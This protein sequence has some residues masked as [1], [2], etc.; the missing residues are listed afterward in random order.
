MTSLAEAPIVRRA[1]GAIHRRMVSVRAF[2]PPVRFATLVA[3]G[4]ALLSFLVPNRYTATASFTVD[5][6]SGTQSLSQLAGL[7]AQLGLTLPS[8]SAASPYLFV[9]LSVSDTVLDHVAQSA[10]P[11]SAFR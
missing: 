3:V 8:A 9:D 2:V 4:A 10:I 5:T 7:T 11:D 1:K 6:P